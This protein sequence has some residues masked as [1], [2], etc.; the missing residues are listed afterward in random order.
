MRKILTGLFYLIIFG[1]ILALA[2]IFYF[3][4]YYKDNLPDYRQLEKYNPPAVSRFY[5]SK[6]KLLEQYAKENR[7][8]VQYRDIPPLV[9]KAFLAAEDKNF[10]DHPGIDFIGVARAIL[11]NVVNFNKSKSLVG[12][13]T[14]T[15]QVV[16]NML[17]SNEKTFSRKIKEAILAFRINQV[18]SKERIL[19]LYLNQ[20][21]LGKGAYGISAAALTYFNKPLDELNLEEVAF[22]AAMPKAPTSY[23]PKT[24]YQ[25]SLDRRNYVLERMLEDGYITED[26]AKEGIKKPIILAQRSADSG[27]KADYF[28]EAV[29]QEIINQFGD[30]VLY[31]GGLSVRTTLDEDLQKLAEKAL[32]NGIIKYDRK[33]GYRGPLAN[34]DLQNWK[35]ELPKINFQKTIYNLAI[36]LQTGKDKANIMTIE[37]Q[38]G[39][40]LLKDSL[41]AKTNLQSMKNLLK[42]GDVILVEEVANHYL[43]AQE[44]EVNGAIVVMQPNTGKV[45][46]LVGGFDYN[47]TK[48][49]RVTQAYRQSGSVFKTFVYLSA[50]ENG[51]PPNYIIVDEPIEVEQGPGLPLWKPKNYKGDF[52]GEI[53]LRTGLEKSRNIVVIKL[54]QIL[55]GKN[56]KEVSKRFGI[57]EMPGENLATVLGSDETTLLRMTNAYNILAS[58]GKKVEPHLIE[59]IQDLYGRLY[60]KRDGSVCS[61]C[62]SA[63]NEEIHFPYL[64]GEEEEFIIDPRSAYQITDILNGVMQRGTGQMG[65]HLGKYIAG[66]TGTTNNSNDAW[67]IGYTKD[68]VVGV[69]VGYDEP[70][71]LGKNATGATI[72]LPI[73]IEFMQSA[74]KIYPDKPFPVPEGI[75]I[76]EIDMDTGKAP[77]ALTRRTIK[78]IFKSKS[79]YEEIEI[80]EMVPIEKIHE[81]HNHELPVDNE[82]SGMGGYY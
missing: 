33:R 51:I 59:Y 45:L 5:S 69:Y 4:H 11:H 32:K 17:L 29:R 35:K 15:Q 3:V 50:L 78:E 72:A 58:Q 60:Y 21:Y 44:P 22:L 28:A 49:N 76:K 2:S 65:K 81:K 82:I 47:D 66:K 30:K 74:L 18:Y 16:K 23:N 54:A 20:I 46:A 36:V 31:E 19:E 75:I 40:I 7:I 10:F 57:S 38:K 63:G 70:R 14:I 48:F 79:D 71:S 34:I 61:A 39:E 12:G 41:W 80:E 25:R 8:F 73:F 9:I 6:G 52:L 1:I 64:E 24:N 42:P 53:T 55:G 67:F 13:S 26:E 27:I 37:G 77:N 43:L 62:V 68:L 56:I